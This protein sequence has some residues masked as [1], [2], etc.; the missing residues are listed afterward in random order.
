MAAIHDSVE[1]VRLL[2]DK[3]VP[4]NDIDN[5]VRITKLSMMF[6]V[7]DAT[8]QD[9]ETALHIACKK[10]SHEVENVLVSEGADQTIKSKVIQNS[11]ATFNKIDQ[12]G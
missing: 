6:I 5:E 4:I 12:W 11:F 10:G 7:F 3:G 9:G 8:T 1:I 2:I